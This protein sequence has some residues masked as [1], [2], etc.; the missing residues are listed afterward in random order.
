MRTTQDE[1]GQ[2]RLW[3]SADDTYEWA[4]RSGASWPCSTL[5]GHRCYVE[6]EPSGDLVDMTIDGRGG[7]ALDDIDGHELTAAASDFLTERYE[8]DHPAIR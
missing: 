4:H 3:L 2:T 8:S 7:N 6:F 1:T 5:S